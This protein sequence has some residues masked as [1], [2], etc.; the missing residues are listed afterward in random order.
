MAKI[1][2]QTKQQFASE[3]LLKCIRGG[4]GLIGGYVGRSTLIKGDLRVRGWIAGS[5][6]VDQCW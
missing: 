2:V 6:K 1:V 3:D 5:K 4:A